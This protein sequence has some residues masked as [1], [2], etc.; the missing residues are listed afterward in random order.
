MYSTR[1]E[2]ESAYSLFSRG[3]EFLASGHP[4]QAALLLGRA[5]LLEP[6]KTSIREA[7]GRALYMSGRPA[8]A[9]R[10]FTKIVEMDPANDFA[11]FALALACDRTGQR[12]R[13]IGHLKLALAMR[14]GREEYRLALERMAG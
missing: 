10:E 13:A 12:Q 2:H 6:K 11:H 14:P 5:K 3:N 7:L 8:R 9:R 4:H 1:D